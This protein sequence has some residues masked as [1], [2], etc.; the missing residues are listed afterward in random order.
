MTGPAVGVVFVNYHSESLIVPRARRFAQAGIPVAVADNSGTFPSSSATVIAMGGNQGF[1]AG[2]NRAAAS[3]P[4]EVTQLCFH[5]PDVDLD[6]ADLH[7]LAEM[8]RAQER[9]GILAPAL[10]TENHLRPNGFRYPSTPREL[11][12]A[13]RAARSARPRPAGEAANAADPRPGRGGR[14]FGSAALA[15]AD[16]PAFVALGGFD[17]SF[18]LYG[19]DLDLW[20]RFT[21][22]GYSTGFAEDVIVAA[23]RKAGSPASSARREL[24]RWLGVELFAERHGQGWRRLRAV[25]LPFF[26]ALARDEPELA[27]RMRPGYRGWRPPSAVMTPVRSLLSAA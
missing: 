27:A 26:N 3:L 23:A 15:L 24:L 14:R 25:H 20:H 12:L 18:F 5:N 10:R 13:A 21:M 2:C 1:G 11:M 4:P 7:R 9:P 8:L 22:G 17:E 16:R 19:E 6:V